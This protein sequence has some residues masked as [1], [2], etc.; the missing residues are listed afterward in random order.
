MGLPAEKH[1]H[2]IDEYLTLELSATDKHEFHDG[3]ILAMSGGSYEAS[4]I[5]CN[6]I[7]ELSTALKGK[8]CHVLE[9]NLRVRIAEDNR[10]VYPDSMIICGAPEFD[11]LDN[12]RHTILNPRV[13]VEVLSPSTE[14][15][16]RGDKFDSYRA[17]PSLEEYL[18]IS[19]DRANVESWLRQPSG[20]WSVLSIT[21]IGAV[22]KVRC[23]GIEI[24]LADI[25]S[26]VEWPGK[27]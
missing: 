17:I 23:L 22:A 3:E 11:P 4:L 12:K 20:D 10:Y 14:A 19:Q 5:A 27:R 7:G 1:R 6:F 24:A 18:M 2:T 16:D 9:S 8:P 21:D 25:Y 15:Y 26:G 13:I